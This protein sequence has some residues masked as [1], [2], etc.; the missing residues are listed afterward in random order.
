MSPLN[1]SRV[2]RAATLAVVVGTSL[3]AACSGEDMTPVTA[4]RTPAAGTPKAA[5][6][7]APTTAATAAVKASAAAAAGVRVR[8]AWA[9]ST[10]GNPDE[11]SAVYLVVENPGGA[12]RLIGATISPPISRT[13][14]LHV[15]EMNNGQMAMRQ[16]EGWDV[17]GSGGTLELKPAG[18][19]V[20]LIALNRQLK[21]GDTVSLTLKFEKAGEIKVDAPVRDAAAAAGGTGGGMAMPK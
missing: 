18:N 17:P 15:T 11:N 12:D 8:D 7:T 20:M 1:P 21:V 16:V 6:T 2:A 5:A 19:H 9:R 13:V 10:A 4:T 14:E 3:L